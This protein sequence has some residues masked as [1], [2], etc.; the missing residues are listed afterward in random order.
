LTWRD[1]SLGTAGL[2][3]ALLDALAAAAGH[4]ISG[5]AAATLL[6]A[7]GL[8]LAG[9]LPRALRIHPVAV[10][11]AVPAVGF[12]A[13]SVALVTVARLGLPLTGLSTRLVIGAIIV[14]ATLAL[15]VRERFERPAW[16]EPALLA[17]ALVAGIVLQG[18]VLHGSPVP[19]NDWAKYLLYADEIRRH[20]SVLI[21]NPYWML[22]V[23]FRDDPGTPAVYGAWLTM[24]DVPVS[25]L[26]HGIWVLAV[27]GILSVFA[28]VRALWGPVAAGIAALLYAVVPINQDILGWHGLANV[29]ALALMPLILLSATELLR[30][31]VGRREAAGLGLLLVALAAAHRLSLTVTGLTLVAAGLV[32]LI[33]GERRRILRGAAW[34]IGATVLLGWG[35]A[36]HLIDVNRTF[37]GTQGYEAYKNSKVN[38]HLVA[39][40]LTWPFVI[41]GA[42]G[43]LCALWA[44]RRR[45]ALGIPL[46]L[47]LVITALAY[48]WKLH[49]P[50]AYLRMAYYVPLA[51]VPLIAALAV[52]RAGRA[53]RGLPAA[54]AAV[55]LAGVVVHSAWARAADVRSF[56]LFADTPSLRGLDQL[57]RQIKPGEPIV[58]D[59]CWSFLSTWL[60][61]TPTLA[62]LYPEDIQPKAELPFARQAQSVLA[63]TPSGVALARRLGVRY[64]LVDPA[65]VAPDGEPIRAPRVGVPVYVSQ[66]LVVLQIPTDPRT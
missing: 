3:I 41:A 51:A 17:F 20:G 42:A 65:C 38:L 37:G 66:R 22:G 26:A 31:R 14:G 35:V 8:A 6:L 49:L 44:V 19:G 7:P 39:L 52:T 55:A 9:L 62:A 18:R 57:T 2:A 45:P 27:M 43:A 53:A 30:G 4:P 64:L 21:D 16:S 47:L 48:S 59:R 23:P 60:V 25:V 13:S 63:G 58:T 5:L 46:A 15:P 40:D 1:R 54:L 34:T 56:Y 50:M 61:H 33:A 11:A 29:A 24:T 12:A 10:L 32:A 36:W 28:W